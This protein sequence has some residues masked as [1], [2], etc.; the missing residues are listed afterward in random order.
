[1]CALSNDKEYLARRCSPE[2]F[3]LRYGVYGIS[4]VWSTGASILPCRVYLRHCVLASQSF[5][6][7][8]AANFLDNTFLADR[9]TSLRVYLERNPSIMDELPPPDLV[10]RYSG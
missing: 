10:G 2:E 9:T 8:A 6:P 3:Q 5:C 7:E 1:M 4:E